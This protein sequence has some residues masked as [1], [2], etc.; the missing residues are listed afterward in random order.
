MSKDKGVVAAGHELTAAAAA[1]ILQDGG[2]AFDACVAGLFMTFVAEAVFSSPGGGGFLM[3]RRAGSDKITLFDFFAETP[4]KRRPASEIDFYPIYADFGPAK[5]EFHIGAGSSATP[6]VVP[7]L[8][9]MHQE[10]CRLPMKRLVEPAV[11]AARAGFPLTAFQAYLLTVIAPILKATTGVAKIFAPEGT[12]LKAGE[13]FSNPD[14]AE[15]IE[16]LAED[17]ARLLV[18]GDVGQAIV[19]QQSDGGYLT[20]PI[21]PTIAWRGGRPSCGRMTV[22]SSRSTR[23]PRQ[24]GR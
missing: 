2:N 12:L 3:A 4:R 5:Q 23:R 18:D 11:R 16:W 14:L 22:R 17:G 24:A 19:A 8:F 20:L 13:T 15:T 1:E 21:L 10:L 7:G 6:G 9:A